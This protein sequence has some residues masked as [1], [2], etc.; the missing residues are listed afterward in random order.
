M[1][2]T[3]PTE[4]SRLEIALFQVNK[5]P[6]RAAKKRGDT[7]E[8]MRPHRVSPPAARYSRGLNQN[9]IKLEDRP[10]C[11]GNK[12]SPRVRIR[13]ARRG[14]TV[15][16][17]SHR[18]AVPRHYATKTSA[19]DHLPIHA[20]YGCVLWAGLYREFGA[21]VPCRDFTWTKWACRDGTKEATERNARGG[22]KEGLGERRKGAQEGWRLNERGSWEC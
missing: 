7:S 11:I 2:Y 16:G 17:T 9:Q 6:T 5:A 1:R 22:E 4:R 19:A 15:C 12:L 14:M 8:M 21:R 18:F 3:A 10:L 13:R 20:I